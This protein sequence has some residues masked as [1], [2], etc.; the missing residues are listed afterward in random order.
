ME[1][2]TFIKNSCIFCVGNAIALPF[3]N[4][5]QSIPIYKT[6]SLNK[7]IKVPVT[8]FGESNYLVVKPADINY[9]IAV[10]KKSNSEYFS[11]VMNC[12]HADNPVIF[13][14]KYF[15]CNLHGST[16][17]I[18]GKVEKGPAEK[19]LVRLQCELIENEININL[20]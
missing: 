20:P 19:S 5:C 9:D 4:S 11:L 6:T 18:Y 8:A 17:S 13:T 3:L 15:Q 10:M 14:G 16:F 12:T 1:R 2:R 7:K